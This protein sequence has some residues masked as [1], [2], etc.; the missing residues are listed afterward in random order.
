M[1]GYEWLRYNPRSILGDQM[2]LGKTAQIGQLLWA[3]NYSDYLDSV[4]YPV[5]LV[6]P[7]ILAYHWKDE[8][9]QFGF[10]V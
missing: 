2:G 8:L 1:K 10:D 7:S 4:V 6:G 9:K 5:L 3:I